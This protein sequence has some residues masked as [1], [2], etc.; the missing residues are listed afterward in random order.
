MRR[1]GVVLAA[2]ALAAC[3]S[4]KPAVVYV[5]VPGEAPKAS[6]LV[7]YQGQSRIVASPFLAPSGRLVFQ[8]ENAGIFALCDKGHLLYVSEPTGSFFVVVNACPGGQP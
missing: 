5:P 1:V 4:A 3:S 2:L 6:P 8:G 7:G